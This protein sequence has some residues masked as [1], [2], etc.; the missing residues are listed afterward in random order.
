ME[1]TNDLNTGENNFVIN[2][3]SDDD[4]FDSTSNRKMRAENKISFCSSVHRMKRTVDQDTLQEE[5]SNRSLKAFYSWWDN[6]LDEIE[7]EEGE[8]DNQVKDLHKTRRN[9][10]G[11]NSRSFDGT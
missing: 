4:F 9:A 3:L 1:S 5:E 8:E 10:I 7:Q 11:S 6:E 2:K